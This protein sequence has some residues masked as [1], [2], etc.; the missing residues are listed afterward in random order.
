MILRRRPAKRAR[1]TQLAGG[2]IDSVGAGFIN[3]LCTTGI[4]FEIWGAGPS[5]GYRYEI[6]MS[7][8]EFDQLVAEV[9]KLRGPDE[10]L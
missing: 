10:R 4:A 5:A 3:A 9:K 8:A 7:Y 6:N 1:Y 2:A